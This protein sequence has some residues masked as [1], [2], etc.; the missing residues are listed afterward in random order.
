MSEPCPVCDS[1]VVPY[2]EPHPHDIDPFPTNERL[3]ELVRSG[4]MRYIRGDVPVEDMTDLLVADLKYTIV[5]FLECE[6]CGGLRMWGLCVRGA[7]IYRVA[8]AD[9]VDRWPWED[10]PPRERWTTR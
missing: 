9:E 8:E 4:A 7:P 5:S 10:A 6:T 1:V 2:A 3:A